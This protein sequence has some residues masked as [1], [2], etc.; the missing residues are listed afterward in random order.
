MG[1]EKALIIGLDGASFNFIDPLVRGGKL[2]NLARLMTQGKSYYLNSTIPSNTPVAWTSMTTGQN[3]GKHGIFGFLNYDHP[4]IK[5]VSSRDNRARCLWD[6][7]G[8]QGKASI[9]I[10][11]PFTWPPQKING[12]MACFDWAIIND[13]SILAEPPS[14]NAYIK[15]QSL[16][17]IATFHHAEADPDLERYHEIVMKESQFTLD[18]AHRFKWELLFVVFMVTDSVMHIY[19]TQKDMI[20]EVYQ[21]VDNA[22][23]QL[24]TLIDL[25]KDRVFI[26]SDHG[27]KLF[28]RAYPV[29]AFFK[30]QRL[31]HLKSSP[32][33]IAQEALS[34]LFSPILAQY[35]LKLP[36]TVRNI[37]KKVTG[38][39][40][41]KISLRDIVDR[42]QSPIF[43]SDEN[44]RI[45]VLLR[46]N[47]RS[48]ANDRVRRKLRQRIFD[49]INRSEMII[50]NAWTSDE[51]YSGPHVGGAPD[52]ILEMAENI[53]ADIDSS[54][55]YKKPRSYPSLTGGHIR[56]GILIAAGNDISPA[57]HRKNA[58]VADITPTILHALQLS[59]PA[60]LDGRVLQ[61]LFDPQSTLGN[62]PTYVEVHTQKSA[63][64]DKTDEV[65]FTR[66]EEAQMKARLQK[67]GYL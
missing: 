35:P 63:P 62:A 28:H 40:A 31:L 57:L 30:E 36:T 12:V 3:P 10:N 27:T 17:K 9:I 66:D 43:L 59:I 2:P 53:A 19:P 18:I 15:E 52:I 65:A 25:S 67:L 61:E 23:G 38:R 49:P 34:N 32:R 48:L 51:V 46:I 26:T 5:V 58:C 37:Y 29:P 42:Q 64:S 24:L 56:K 45:D 7:L 33:N 13:K 1:V 20:S 14:V 6:Y 54:S 22:I 4:G 8:S 21:I 39:K 44:S 60:S 55:F 47:D 11:L 50:Q 41:T 16:D